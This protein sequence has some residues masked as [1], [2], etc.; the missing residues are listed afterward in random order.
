MKYIFSTRYL[1]YACN[2]EATVKHKTTKPEQKAQTKGQKDFTRLL[3]NTKWN[4]PRAHF[5]YKSASF[6]FQEAQPYEAPFSQ[7]AGLCQN[8][9]FVSLHQKIQVTLQTLHHK[10]FTFS[11]ENILSPLTQTQK[12]TSNLPEH[13]KVYME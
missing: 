5:A 7:S 3:K 8:W 13:T 6:A 2:S 4:H 11:S 12:S 9:F 1:Q 10:C